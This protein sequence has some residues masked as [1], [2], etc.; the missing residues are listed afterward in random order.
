MRPT[1]KTATRF[2]VRY[3]MVPK[4]KIVTLKMKENDNLLVAFPEDGKKHIKWDQELVE[5]KNFKKNGKINSQPESEK[6]PIKSILKCK[7][8]EVKPKP[9]EINRENSETD[10]SSGSE[11]A[12]IWRPNKTLVYEGKFTAVRRSTAKSP[13]PTKS[14]KTRHVSSSVGRLEDIMLTKFHRSYGVPVSVLH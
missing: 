3:N 10:A 4:R 7:N 2:P 9:A 14:K 11:D 5:V 8:V 13:K 12:E 1:Y 6:Q